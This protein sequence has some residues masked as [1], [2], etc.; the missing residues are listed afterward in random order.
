[1]KKARGDLECRN[2]TEVMK[3]LEEG[4]RKQGGQSKIDDVVVLRE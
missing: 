2:K 3:R 4:S 1:M